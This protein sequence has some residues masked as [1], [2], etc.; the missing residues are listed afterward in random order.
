MN[1][2]L[3]FQALDISYVQRYAPGFFSPVADDFLLC[4]RWPVLR[5]LTLT[6]LWCTPHTGLD[7]AAAFLLAHTTLEVLHLDVAFGTA[8][9]AGAGAGALATLKFPPHCLPRLRELKGV[10]LSRS[11]ARDRVFLKNLKG[12]GDTVCRL[13][14]VGWNEVEGVRRRA[15]SGVRPGVGVT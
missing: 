14:L 3:L 2:S 7:T 15:D 5:S 10:R 4:G 9:A 13:E 8:T 12:G 11:A 1:E 6:N